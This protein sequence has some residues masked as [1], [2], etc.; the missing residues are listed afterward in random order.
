MSTLVVNTI[1]S[2]LIEHTNGTDAMLI[3]SAGR[4]TK[5]N[6]PLFYVERGFG[7]LNAFVTGGT[8]AI[9]TWNIFRI[10]QGNHFTSANGR[11]TA[12]VAGVYLFTFHISYNTSATDNA[13]YLFFRNG[14][15]VSETI[16]AKNNGVNLWGNAALIM[17]ISLSANDFVTVGA[18][19]Y[20]NN[21]G[22]CRAS[23][24]GCLIG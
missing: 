5:P 22:S 6:H 21:A 1:Q 24:G 23:F 7:N 19:S 4:V 11:F 15:G 18:A 9:A 8:T 20:N 12:P 16:V 10:N 3:D 14:S 17:H 13:D 2:T